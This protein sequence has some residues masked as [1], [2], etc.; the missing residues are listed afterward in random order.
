MV[1]KQSDGKF[2]IWKGFAMT[3][4]VRNQWNIF[5]VLGKKTVSAELYNQLNYLQEWVWNKDMFTTNKSLLKEL[6]E[7]ILPEEQ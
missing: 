1:L 4:R 5:Q 2:F 6:L 7:D 3:V